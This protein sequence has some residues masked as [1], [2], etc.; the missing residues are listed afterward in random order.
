MKSIRRSLFRRLFAGLALLSAVAGI[1]L[2]V[3]I[4]AGLQARFDADL[5]HLASG[6][7][8]A[9]LAS[10][11]KRPAGPVSAHWELFFEPKSGQYF[12]IWTADGAVRGRSRSLGNADLPHPANLGPEPRYWDLV[13]PGGERVRATGGR[14]DLPRTPASASAADP[15]RLDMVVARNR[16]DLDRLLDRI[17]V[18]ISGVGLLIALGFALLVHLAVGVGLQPLRQVANQAA[19]IRTDRLNERFEAQDAPEELRPIID[20]LNDL[21]AR[22]EA[23][24]ERERRCSADLAHELRTP[25]AE[26][27][28]TAEVALRWPGSS[29]E[30]NYQEILEIS[31]R[32][33]TILDSLLAL[34]RPGPGA[35][36]TLTEAISVTAVL[37]DCWRPFAGRAVEKGL[38][39]EQS[40]DSQLTTN[41]HAGLFRLILSNLFSNA[42]EY[43]PPGGRIRVEGWA[44]PVGG[45]ELVTAN[46]VTDLNPQDIPHLFERFWRRDEARTGGKHHGLGLCVAKSCAEA[47][48]YDLTAELDAQQHWL[49]FRLRRLPTQPG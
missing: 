43:T 45:M 6:V 18:G 29:H 1:S 10:D 9:M 46:T 14:V 12:Q 34:A 35:A 17:I 39:F 16:A 36:P 41:T 26:L 49:A 4:R 5:S 37:A 21:M 30:E 13:L 19:A 24:F 3:M 28:T 40:V 47:L 23:G 8:L 20:R 27:K 48:S 44:A 22:L 25:V 38:V 32:M 15:L 42:V 7:P 31:E 33:Q 11:S 2:Y